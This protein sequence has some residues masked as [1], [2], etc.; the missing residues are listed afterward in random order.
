MGVDWYFE[1]VWPLKEGEGLDL[2]ILKL[3]HKRTG[4]PL[5]E[6]LKP[7][8]HLHERP[9]RGGDDYICFIDTN[10][11]VTL[12][13]FGDIKWRVGGELVSLEELMRREFPKLTFPDYLCYGSVCIRWNR[14]EKVRYKPEVVEVVEEL[15]RAGYDPEVEIFVVGPW[16]G[17]HPSWKDLEPPEGRAPCLRPEKVVSD[18]EGLL[19]TLERY[20]QEL[21]DPVNSHNL[22]RHF[23]GCFS[24]ASIARGMLEPY[25]NVCRVARRY[26]WWVAAG[27][28]V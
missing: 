20:D 21:S 11:A 19:Q 17:V 4:Y 9:W 2:Y 18:L 28:P 6:P 26:G 8:V 3:V 25:F 13:L 16:G 5:P 27:I 22:G 10:G 14:V 24:F 7:L 12:Q 23:R 1:C 15:I